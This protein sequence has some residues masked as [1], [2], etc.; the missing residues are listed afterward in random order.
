MNRE[1]LV[2]VTGA[3]G[4]LGSSTVEALVAEGMRVRAFDLDTRKNRRKAKRLPNGVE[5]RFGDVTSDRDVAEAVEGA[6]AVVH[7][8][9]LLPPDTERV[10]QLAREINVQGTKR[11]VTAAEATTRTVRFVEASSYTVYGPRVPNGELVGAA[12]PVAASDVYSQTK[13][14]AE[15]IVRASSLEW[16]IFRVAAAVDGSALA[17]DRLALSLMFEV[18]PRQPIELVHGKDLALAAAHAVNEPQAVHRILPIGGGPSCRLRQR[19]LFAMTERM[20]G[21]APLPDTAFGRSPYYTCWLDTEESERVLR[22][23]RHSAADI[24]RDLSRRLAPLKPLI[25][26]ARPI[27]RWRLLSLSGPYRGAPPRPTWKAQIEAHTKLRQ[28]RGGR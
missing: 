27:V 22:F 2:L 20:L 10:P 17:A 19:E 9:G 13:L 18:D 5:V 24:E 7:F 28:R 25:G 4:N 16:V 11:V 8:A 6:D 1:K 26:L 3:L 15:G 23:Q 12:T 14:A 21:I